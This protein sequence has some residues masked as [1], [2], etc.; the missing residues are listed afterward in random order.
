MNLIH[1]FFTPTFTHIYQKSKI[2][3]KLYIQTR[4]K[5]VENMKLSKLILNYLFDICCWSTINSYIHRD[6]DELIYSMS[7][8]H[9]PPLVLIFLFLSS[10][11]L[12]KYNWEGYH[13][14]S[15]VVVSS[16]FLV[17]L[18]F[19]FLLSPSWVFL[20]FPFVGIFVVAFVDSL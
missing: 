15:L 7:Y 14:S 13:L 2:L 17:T 12:C 9:F 16:F 11:P 4:K 3:M 19:V 20:L 1:E 18:D 6:I 8:H 5:K 10:L